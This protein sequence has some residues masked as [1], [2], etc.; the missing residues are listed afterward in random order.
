MRQTTVMAMPK[1]EETGGE[2]QEETKSKRK[3]PDR[4]GRKKYDMRKK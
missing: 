3:R 4:D 2:R 1:Q